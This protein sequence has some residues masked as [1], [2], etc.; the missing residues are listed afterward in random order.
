[1]TD[2][3]LFFATGVILLAMVM[4]LIRTAL[5]PGWFERVLTLN[6]L[7]SLTI[8]LLVLIA[9]IKEFY[10][11]IDIALLYVLINF[12]STLGILVFFKDSK[13]P[14]QG[15]MVQR[16]SFRKNRP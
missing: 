7:G 12:V 11:L 4:T 14:P 15:K 16:R 1:M 9:V 6:T 2:I 3:A 10:S 5:G 13:L 8:T